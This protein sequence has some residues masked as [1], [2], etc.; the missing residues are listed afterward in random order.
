MIELELKKLL[1][2]NEA[3]IKENQRL[4]ELIKQLEK[5]LRELEAEKK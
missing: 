2:N 3:L 4:R 1:L 5:K